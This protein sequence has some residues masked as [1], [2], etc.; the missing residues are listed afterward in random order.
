MNTKSCPP[1]GLAAILLC[2]LT[3]AGCG[4]GAL[5]LLTVPADYKLQSADLSPAANGF[6]ASNIQ[7]YERIPGHRLVVIQ[8]KYKSDTP[9][10]CFDERG[11]KLPFVG[12]FIEVDTAGRSA[13]MARELQIMG[14]GATVAYV[15]AVPESVKT[16]D[17]TGY[18]KQALD[19][20]I[21]VLTPATLDELKIN[22]IVRERN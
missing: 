21:P 3:L 5:Q 8:L 18:G 7:A 15:F 12:S 6:E 17:V 19:K 9:L 11:R 13:T 22:H 20:L 16:I 4:G 10:R 2:V 14:D 1:S